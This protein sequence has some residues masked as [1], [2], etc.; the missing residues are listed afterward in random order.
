MKLTAGVVAMKRL[1]IGLALT[2]LLM[3]AATAGAEVTLLFTP[4]NPRVGD[5]VDVTVQ[6]GTGAKSV[7]YD[8]SVPDKHVFAGKEDTHFKAAFRPRTEADYTLKV[9]VVYED[10]SR[11]EAAVTVP[12]RGRAETQEGPDVIYSQKDGWW[13][14]KSYGKSSLEKAGCAIFT[15]SHAV[16][17]LGF[18]GNDLLPETLGVTYSGCLV[19]GGTA[20]ERLLTRAGTVYDFTTQDELIESKAEIADNLREGNL[21]SFSVVIGHIA[22]G[23]ELS[24]DGKKVRIVDSAPSA[25]FERIKKGAIWY[26]TEDGR[27]AEAKTVE[28]VPG[29]RWF[30]ET[31]HACGLEYWLDIDYCA[32]RGIRLIQPR[33]LHVIA[34]GAKA[35]ADLVQFGAVKSTVDLNGEE[36][37]VET[38]ALEWKTDVPEN[39]RVAIVSRKKGVIFRDGDGEK[40]EGFK[41]ISVG[42]VLPVLAEDSERVRVMY[43][44]RTGYLTREYVE[45]GPVLSGQGLKEGILSLKGKTKG[46][47]T[48]KIRAEASSKA[49]VAAEW[50]IGTAVTVLG[51]DNEFYHIEAR[52][53][54]G[55]VHQDYLLIGE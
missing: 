2:V 52:G 50:K 29:F 23:C 33:W 55:W 1:L 4:D 28:E 38:A 18:T 15:L 26:R 45:L 31:Q 16:Q 19:Q 48:V 12:V 13:K 34:D 54:Q 30:F 47:V 9:T 42:T 14:D 10:R 36:Q 37:T 25:T 49:T 44:G 53:Q 6:A 32:R 35:A 21:F 41:N 24:E 40:V 20:N 39:H 7:I 5:T 27:F 3:L 17:R 11:E 51:K 43:R 22:L 8:L 46:T